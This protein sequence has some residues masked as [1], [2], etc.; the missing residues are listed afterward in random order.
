MPGV[1]DEFVRTD[2]TSMFPSAFPD[3]TL[4]A[5]PQART[6]ER[7]TAAAVDGLASTAAALEGYA[8]P[9]VDLMLT[10]DPC[11]QTYLSRQRVGYPFHLGRSLRVPGDPP[12]MPTLYVQSCSGGIFEHD[13]LAWRI[14]AGE[15]T[16][17]HLTTSASTIVHGMQAGN[18]VQ[19]VCIE[20]QA[21]CLLEYL[22]DPLVLFPGARLATRLRLRVHPE[23]TVL[24][25]D[26]LVP[27][28]PHGAGSHF[29][30]IH[31][32][33]TVEDPAGAPIARDRYRL[34]GAALASATPGVTGRFP[35][36]GGFVA[37]CEAARVPGLVDALRASL[38]AGDDVYAGVSQL[39]RRRGA[40]MRVLARDA[41]AL[42]EAL[43]GAWYA[44][45]SVLVGA[46]PMP[47]RK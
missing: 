26:S 33:L 12:G 30:W 45:R 17:A 46:A 18:A 5:G 7:L 27:H 28:D 36:Q 38:P 44:A 11:G 6:G 21:G 22:P 2:S 15:G 42:R 19:E 31:A 23:A 29:D 24:A 8:P 1:F 39:P 37:L 43:C 40:W 13:R 25:C 20:A 3:A 34:T 4:S 35:C 9:Q 47:R 14:V 32:E 16:Q 10:A 41:A